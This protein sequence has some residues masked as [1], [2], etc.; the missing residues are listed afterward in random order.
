MTQQAIRLSVI[1]AMTEETEFYPKFAK[2]FPDGETI[3]NHTVEDHR[4]LDRTLVQL[5]KTD[6]S[7]AQF[8]NYVREAISKFTVRFI[9]LF[10][11]L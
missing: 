4:S 6:P 2:M 1:H 3:R 7:D 9:Y 11:I 8:D 5:E 10:P